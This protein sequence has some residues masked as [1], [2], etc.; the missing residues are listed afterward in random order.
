MLW[1]EE[2]RMFRP[3]RKAWLLALTVV[4]GACGEA[5]SRVEMS[6]KEFGDKWPFTVDQITLRCGDPQRHHVVF[7]AGG[8]TYALNGSA[9]GSALVKSG[10]WKDSDT[11]RKVDREKAAQPD[12]FDRPY[13]D[14]PQTFIDRG[15]EPYRE[16]RRAS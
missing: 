6:A 10:Q 4:V 14:L 2:F 7:D 12:L 15:L 8:V 11:V 1:S 9:R 5:G 3:T 13:T 16:C